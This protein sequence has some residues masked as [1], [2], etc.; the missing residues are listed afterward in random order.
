MD[1]ASQWKILGIFEARNIR[2][3]PCIKG[4]LDFPK[5]L[6]T[7]NYDIDFVMGRVNINKVFVVRSLSLQFLF[8]Y[9]YTIVLRLIKG[10]ETL[11][12]SFEY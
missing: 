4:L 9:I 2:I 6:T 10:L 7:I 3:L 8:R 5:S 12:N 11:F 1:W